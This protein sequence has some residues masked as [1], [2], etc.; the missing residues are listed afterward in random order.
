MRFSYGARAE[1]YGQWNYLIAYTVRD[2]QGGNNSTDIYY[3]IFD[4][5][6]GSFAGD[7]HT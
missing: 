3:R 2:N 6:L 4:P 5:E 7:S 1:E